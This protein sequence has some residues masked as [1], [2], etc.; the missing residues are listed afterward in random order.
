MCYEGEGIAC[1]QLEGAKGYRLP[2]Q[3]AQANA[4]FIFGLMSKKMEVYLVTGPKR[5][6]GLIKVA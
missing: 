4:Q 1:D 6:S 2:G 5:K 3:P